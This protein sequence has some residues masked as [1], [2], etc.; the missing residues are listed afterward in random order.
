MGLGNNTT[1][2]A[3]QLPG[4]GPPPNATVYVRNLEERIKPGELIDALKELFS[5]YGEIIDVVAKTNLKAKGQAFVVFDNVESA[6][7][8]IEDV[9]GFDLFGKPMQLAFAKT[10]RLAEKDKKKAAEQ[11][12]EQKRLKHTAPAGMAPD[13]GARP[14]KATRGAGLKSTNAGAAA[15]IPDEYLP[16]NK[17]LFLQNLP[18]DYDIDALTAIFGRFEG[19]REVRLVPGRRGIAFVEYDGEA[20]AI[21]AKENTAGMALGDGQVMK[22]TYQ[23]Q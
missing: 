11:A 10:R 18:E 2:M 13:G 7:K 14:I 9:Q 15:V 22:V 3:T 16:P 1:K 8:C 5:E 4:G 17:I 19:F 23:R 20:G 21:S 12:E 6:Q